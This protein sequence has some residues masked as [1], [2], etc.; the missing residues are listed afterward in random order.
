MAVSL[1]VDTAPVRPEAVV[2]LVTC[3][4]A[5]EKASATPAATNSCRTAPDAAEVAAAAPATAPGSPA[6]SPDAPD[7]VLEAPVACRRETGDP[8][9]PLV[10]GALP[11]ASAEMYPE[12]ALTVP[13]L[14]EA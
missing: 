13:A 11:E 2:R 5:C 10:A 1:A 7:T 12:E 3:P 8:E 9:A 6:S 4:L 14:P